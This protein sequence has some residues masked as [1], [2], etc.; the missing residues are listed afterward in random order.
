MAS[1]ANVYT[2]CTAQS[3]FTEKARISTGSTTV[4]FQVLLSPGFSDTIYSAALQI[5]ANTVFDTY[6]GIGN[7]V[8]IVGANFTAEETGSQA[9][10]L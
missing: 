7:K 5:P 2:S 1:Q 3:W 9:R 4:T 8:T 10:T 6:V